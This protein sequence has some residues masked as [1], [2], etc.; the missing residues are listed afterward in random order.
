MKTP[1]QKLELRIFYLSPE[2]IVTT[3][4]VGGPADD[5]F[6]EDCFTQ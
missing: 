3:S 2:D 6:M 1:Y 5:P 4:G